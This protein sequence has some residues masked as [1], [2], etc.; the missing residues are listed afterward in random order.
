MKI[1]SDEW[2]RILVGLTEILLSE[3]GLTTRSLLKEFSDKI[4]EDLRKDKKNSNLTMSMLYTRSERCGSSSRNFW[5]Y[6]Y[7]Y[8]YM[9]IYI[10][11]IVLTNSFQ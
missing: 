5:L 9:Y 4:D 2:G 7:I 8:M 1:P 6:I 10:K 3:Y 11:E